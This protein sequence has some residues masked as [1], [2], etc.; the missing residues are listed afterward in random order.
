MRGI[1]V[2]CNGHVRMYA[3]IF[4]MSFPRSKMGGLIRQALLEWPVASPRSCCLVKPEAIPNQ[5]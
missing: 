3:T 2:E 5:I 4:F 1:E